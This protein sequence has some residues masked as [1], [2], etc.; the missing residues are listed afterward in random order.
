MGTPQENHVLQICLLSSICSLKHTHTHYQ[1][2]LPKVLECVVAYLITFNH[3]RMNVGY[4]LRS[5]FV[6]FEVLSQHFLWR[7]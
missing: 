1:L 2:C 4:K 3:V 5:V 6:L 7:D